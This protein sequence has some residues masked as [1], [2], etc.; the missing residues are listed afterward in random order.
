MVNDVVPFC[1]SWQM[2][3]VHV[4]VV[5]QEPLLLLSTSNLIQEMRSLVE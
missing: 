5:Y 3:K 2:D 4:I 1:G